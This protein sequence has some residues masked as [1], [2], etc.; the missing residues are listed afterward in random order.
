METYLVEWSNKVSQICRCALRSSTWN[1]GFWA[2]L[3]W[4]FGSEKS[5]KNIIAWRSHLCSTLPNVKGQTETKAGHQV[6]S[7]IDNDRTA[8]ALL[9][10]R[11][12]FSLRQAIFRLFAFISTIWVFFWNLRACTNDNSERNFNIYKIERDDDDDEWWWWRKPYRSAIP[13]LLW[14]FLFYLPVSWSLSVKWDDEGLNIDSTFLLM[15]WFFT[16]SLSS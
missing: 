10:L 6:W 3:N 14:K 2:S 7:E 4:F 12:N 15:K 16:L 1:T 8:V 13:Q 11:E 9:T 5:M